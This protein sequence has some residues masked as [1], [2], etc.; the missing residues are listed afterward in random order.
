[1]GIFL[2]ADLMSDPMPADLREKFQEVTFL[3]GVAR[4]RNLK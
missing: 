4:R 3:I 1:M 2:G